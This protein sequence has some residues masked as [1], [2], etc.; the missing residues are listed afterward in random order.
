MTSLSDL[1]TTKGS[2][3][4]YCQ[5]L[6]VKGEELRQFLQ[7]TDQSNK[8]DDEREETRGVFSTKSSQPSLLSQVFSTKQEM[9]TNV[10]AIVSPAMP[11]QVLYFR[12]SN[13]NSQFEGN[14][15]L[16]GLLFDVEESNLRQKLD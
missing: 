2:F 9:K 13:R 16:L 10:L 3:Q 4:E 15:S 7:K 12:V 8:I 14:N 6:R 11:L 5:N 1:D